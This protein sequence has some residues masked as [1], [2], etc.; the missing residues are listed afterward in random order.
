[1]GKVFDFSAGYPSPQAI[2][3]AGGT[4][5]ILYVSGS[6]SGTNFGGKKLTREIMDAYKAAGIERAAIWQH[7]KPGTPSGSDWEHGYNRGRADAAQALSKWL[8]CGGNGWTPIYF[9]VDVDITLD[10]WNSTAVHYFRGA[11]DE[12]GRDWVGIYGHSRVC[13]WAIEDG[14]VGESTTPGKFWTWQCNTWPRGVAPNETTTLYQRVIHTESQPGELVGGIM[15]D[16]NDICAPDWGQD[17]I[18]RRPGAVPPPPPVQPATKEPSYIMRFLDQTAGAQNRSSRFGSAIRLFV[19]HT[20]EGNGNAQSLMDYCANPSRGVGYHFYIDNATCIQGVNTDDA[21]WSVMDANSYCINMCFAGSRAAQSREVWLRDFGNAIDYAAKMFVEL[22]KKYNPL[23]PIV[24][25][26]A[27][28]RAGK[29]GGTDHNGITAMGI[30]NHTDCGPNFPWD[31]YSAAVKKYATGQNIPVIVNV[32]DEELKRIG[33]EAGWIGKRILVNGQKEGS[34][35]DG[36]GKYAVFAG[37]YIYYHPSMGAKAIPAGIMETYKEHN[38]EV[39]ELGYPTGDHTVLKN[40]DG[41]VK[42][43]VQGFQFG[44]IYRDVLATQGF[45]LKG[46]IRKLF[47]R[48]DYENGPLGFPISNEADFVG[49][50]YQDFQGGRAVWPKGGAVAIQAQAGYDAFILDPKA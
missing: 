32:I 24:I 42:G 17:S 39:G 21:S 49:G 18:D 33:G 44:A 2:K 11:C 50:K 26:H 35:R 13:A 12:I 14:V 38:Y 8:G 9:A 25:G 15:C 40:A 27:E 6:R 30:G 23:D 20:Q 10:Q 36:V 3:A 22:A 34:C 16:V 1:M 5:V 4:G 48:L 29:S 37:G 41:S 47:N 31:V 28:L 43:A 7:G 45:I 19:L 46:E